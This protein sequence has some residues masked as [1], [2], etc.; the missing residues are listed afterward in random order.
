MMHESSTKIIDSFR[1]N[2]V[3]LVE[4]YTLLYICDRIFNKKKQ[5]DSLTKY[6]SKN[7]II[8]HVSI[9]EN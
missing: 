1:R 7:N 8:S 6:Y 5:R 9:L 2:T 4:P 3:E